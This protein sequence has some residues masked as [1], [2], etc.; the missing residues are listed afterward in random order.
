MSVESV[1]SDDEFQSMY[2]SNFQTELDDFL[3]FADQNMRTLQE[4]EDDLV[5]ERVSKEQRTL[6]E[7]HG[8][9]TREEEVSMVEVGDNI[10]GVEYVDDHHCVV[11]NTLVEQQCH[12]DQRSGMSPVISVS[13]EHIY[14][15]QRDDELER[16]VKMLN[17]D[18]KAPE[19]NQLG[20][21]PFEQLEKECEQD[22]RDA[23]LVND[24]ANG[25]KHTF[26]VNPGKSLENLER[27][28]DEFDS[29]DRTVGLEGSQ[30][31]VDLC[32]HQNREAFVVSPPIEY[33]TRHPAMEFDKISEEE[34]QSDDTAS[35][36]D[37]LLLTTPSHAQGNVITG[38]ISVFPYIGYGGLEPVQE[39][40]W[41][42]NKEDGVEP[43]I[44]QETYPTTENDDSGCEVL[45]VEGDV[46]KTGEEHKKVM[47]YDDDRLEER[48]V[49]SVAVS[50]DVLNQI[51][52]TEARVVDGAEQHEYTYDSGES[53][54]CTNDIT[55]HEGVEL[56]STHRM[57][58][59]GC[60]AQVGYGPAET[61]GLSGSLSTC[62][63]KDYVYSPKLF[64]KDLPCE[65]TSS[66]N[67][68]D[69]LPD[70]Q[71]NSV[72]MKHGKI[73]IDND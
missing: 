46:C 30:R 71:R 38:S 40:E 16:D 10:R 51:V 14:F 36:S 7:V 19:D 70:Y 20:G 49:V 2:M 1:L 25:S 56:D 17:Y 73:I 50:N 52:I 53:D 32:S 23:P 6:E 4:I 58:P 41:G 47:Y 61:E 69:V 59:Q 57:S 72:Q 68:C 5:A 31:V 39:D 67:M 48:E 43:S 29:F 24:C 64:K 21:N 26:I 54:V 60:I 66:K 65:N 55:P 8:G 3:T 33:T 18:V 37:G 12:D 44:V 62:D 35:P 9:L 11:R 15:I 45:K 34:S 13:E 42:T 28:L 22:I 63:I 27:D